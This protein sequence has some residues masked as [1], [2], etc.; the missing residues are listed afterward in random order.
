VVWAGFDKPQKIYRGAFGRELALPVWVD[1]MNASIEHYPPKEIAGP[2]D[3]K[4]TE[5]CSRSGLLA[6]DR[7]YD[8]VKGPNGDPVQRRTT[9]VEIGT[10]A[11]LPA[12]PCNI[13][14]E[15]RG[16]LVHEAEESEF[17]RA[18]S[19][20]DLAEIRPVVP[21]APTLL[22]DKDPYNSVR[23][24]VQATPAPE[25]AQTAAADISGKPAESPSAQSIAPARTP[26]ADAP[27]M[28]AIPATEP[29]SVQAITPARTPAPNAPIMKAIPVQP[30]ATSTP[31]E[32]RKAVPVGPLDEEPD[33]SILNKA[34]TPPPAGLNE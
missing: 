10:A 22:A 14:G 6:T 1:V 5:I 17:P 21:K 26:A 28:K 32:I 30:Q 11:Q 12:E 18:A 23:A 24:L 4:K 7:C 19:A 27:I 29:P 34:A 2:P 16:R 31:A 9:Y 13:H 33:D 20:V 8:S 25:P 3:V 15:P